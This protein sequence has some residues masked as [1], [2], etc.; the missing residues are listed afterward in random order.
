MSEDDIVEHLRQVAP[1][2]RA[3]INSNDLV[4][5]PIKNGLLAAADEIER[6]RQ[7]MAAWKN[8]AQEL[9]MYSAMQE[10]KEAAGE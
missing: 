6:L 5:W 4:G 3:I 9:T 2:A 1:Y 8:V 10:L 7:E